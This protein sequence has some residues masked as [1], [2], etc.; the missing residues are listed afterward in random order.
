M[1]MLFLEREKKQHK[2]NAYAFWNFIITHLKCQRRKNDKKTEFKK[3][4][5]NS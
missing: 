1:K 5:R 2:E 4:K 3:T